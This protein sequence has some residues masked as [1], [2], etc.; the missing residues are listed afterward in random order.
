MAGAAAPIVPNE[1]AMARVAAAV[2]RPNEA[3]LPRIVLNLLFDP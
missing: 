1:R 3:N 2:D